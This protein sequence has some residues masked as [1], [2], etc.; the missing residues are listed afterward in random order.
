MQSNGATEGSVGPAV[1]RGE[2]R[3]LPL[4]LICPMFHVAVVTNAGLCV[5]VDDQSLLKAGGSF[6]S[7]LCPRS[8][9]TGK[10]IV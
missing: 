3:P 6:P 1:V 10:Y 8:G 7:M 4:A 5:F 2:S 9:G